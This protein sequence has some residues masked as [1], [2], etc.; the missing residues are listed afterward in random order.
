MMLSCCQR[1][2]EVTTTISM[3]TTSKC[4]VVE[5][6]VDKTSFGIAHRRA[7][8]HYASPPIRYPFRTKQEL[9][10][11]WE[12]APMMF[13]WRFDESH[14][15]PGNTK[16]LPILDADSMSRRQLYSRVLAEPA[17]IKRGYSTG[18]FSGD[19]GGGGGGIG[20]TT[21]PSSEGFTSLLSNGDELLRLAE[22]CRVVADSVVD[23]PSELL[24]VGGIGKAA[25][26]WQKRI[27]W[28]Q[29]LLVAVQV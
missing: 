3:M 19:L 2:N 20:E 23:A 22:H 28:F 5:P 21:A 25:L 13:A 11:V 1:L 29:V 10:G 7:R 6:A 24:A 9:E 27:C 8:S 15:S 26:E 16:Q 17:L 4:R 18:G 14:S 12:A